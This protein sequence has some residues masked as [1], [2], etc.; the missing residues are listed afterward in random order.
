MIKNAIHR[1]PKNT[2][3][4]IENQQNLEE[5]EKRLKPFKKMLGKAV[6][7]VLDQEVSSYPIFIVAQQAVDIGL[8]LLKSDQ[9]EGDWL[10]NI[11]TLEELSLIHI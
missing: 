8:P 11:S 7:T 9:I 10:V 1:L 5:I 6:D 2:S 3:N 4:M